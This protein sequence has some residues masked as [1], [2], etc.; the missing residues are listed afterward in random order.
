MMHLDG[1]GSGDRLPPLCQLHLVD[2]QTRPGFSRQM[3]QAVNQ[4]Q[5]IFEY[6]ISGR[7]SMAD[8]TVTG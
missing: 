2:A 5:E 3:K 7:G 1:W 8:L 6:R 4:L